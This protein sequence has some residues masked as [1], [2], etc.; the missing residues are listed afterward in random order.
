MKQKLDILAK[1]YIL[2]F[3]QVYDI[4][5]VFINKDYANSPQE[6]Q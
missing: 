5:K 4:I 1:V 2:T 3:E 6:L